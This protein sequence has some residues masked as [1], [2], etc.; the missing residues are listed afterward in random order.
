[1]DQ[2]LPS[3]KVIRL[4]DYDYSSAGAYFVTM[5]V[6]DKLNLL[7]S[8]VGSGFH[9]RPHLNSARSTFGRAWKPD[10]TCDNPIEYIPHESDK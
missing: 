5:C 10:P 6:K 8:I 1:M 4:K 3:R 9:A 7:G 2:K